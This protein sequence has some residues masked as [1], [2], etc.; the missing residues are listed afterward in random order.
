MNNYYIKLTVVCTILCATL[1]GHAQNNVGIYALKDTVS[2]WDK[3]YKSEIYWSFYK[4]D[5]SNKTLQFKGFGTFRDGEKAPVLDSL[6]TIFDGNSKSFFEVLSPTKIKVPRIK[7]TR[8]R[9]AWNDFAT[10]GKSGSE[11][12]QIF[13][14]KG[15]TLQQKGSQYKHVLDNKLTEQYLH[16][17]HR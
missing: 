11:P 14:I 8:H 9:R 1:H 2:L 15:D 7:G 4:V 17:Q 5:W 10:S 12:A 6:T 16:E 13:L 3:K